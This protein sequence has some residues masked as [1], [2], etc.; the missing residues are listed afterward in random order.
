M[1]EKSGEDKR[2]LSPPKVPL[3]NLPRDRNE[4]LRQVSA[5]ARIINNESQNMVSSSEVLSSYRSE[6]PNKTETNPA[7]LA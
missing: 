7:S 5:M 4:E 3:L 1:K 2:S 6:I